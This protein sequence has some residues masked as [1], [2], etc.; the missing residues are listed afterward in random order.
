DDP[1][2]KHMFFAQSE[3]SVLTWM[4]KIVQASYEH[5]RAKMIMLRVQIRRK[6]GKDPLE[7]LGTTPLPQRASWSQ[8]Y[9]L[10]SFHELQISHLTPPRSS[11]AP[12]LDC[13]DVDSASKAKYSIPSKSPRLFKRSPKPPPR[14]AKQANGAA[15][16]SSPFPH[17]GQ[18]M[19]SFKSHIYPGKSEPP[20]KST[21][22]SHYLPSRSPSTKST[23]KSHI[24]D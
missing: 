20:D 2:K 11:S 18:N 24:N 4:N 1:E 7:H 8:D 12:P 15:S 22:K 13:K 14:K 23:F 6:T 16:N 10:N 3:Q 9:S 5:L 17:V 19:A 21:S